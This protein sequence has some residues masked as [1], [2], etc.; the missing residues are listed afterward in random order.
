MH[1]FQADGIRLIYIGAKNSSVDTL[2]RRTAKI[3]I[4]PTV[5]RSNTVARFSAS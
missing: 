2:A 5:L 1:V 4:Q 3:E